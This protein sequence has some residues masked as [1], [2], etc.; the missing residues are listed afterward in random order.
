MGLCRRELSSGNFLGVIAAK[1]FGVQ[2]PKEFNIAC[3]L[4]DFPIVLVKHLG[5]PVSHVF[6]SR[7]R[8]IPFG[9]VVTAETMPENIFRPP[10]IIGLISHFSQFL[11]RGFLSHASFSDTLRKERKGAVPQ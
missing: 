1:L 7:S 2:R 11:S 3:I 6:R 4:D 8:R 5:I 9:E 10:L